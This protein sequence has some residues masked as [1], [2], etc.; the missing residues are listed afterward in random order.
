ML[1]TSKYK[2]NK[3]TLS[4]AFVNY[5]NKHNITWKEFILICKTFNHI[6]MKAVIETGKQYKLPKALGTIA[7][8]K[9]RSSRLSYIDFNHFNKTGEV[10]RHKNKHSEGYY[11][12]F[13]WDKSAPH[14]RVSNK[15]RIKYVPVRF[16][17]RTLARAII[18]N[19]TISKYFGYD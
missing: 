18:D 8:I 5:D 9:K 10:V 15:M 12:K 14:C 1:Q 11:A 3:N 16:Y 6:I 13:Y 17:K 4:D 19:N 2:P 7:I